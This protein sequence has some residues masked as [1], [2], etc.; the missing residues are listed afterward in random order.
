MKQPV[1]L[2]LLT[3]L[4]CSFSA[5]AHAAD[6]AA[7]KPAPASP[8]LPA[9]SQAAPAAAQK[10][11]EAAPAQ[12]TLRLGHVDIARVAAE[13]E[14]GKAEQTQIGELKKKLQTP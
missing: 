10:S 2:I 8:P 12:Q 3:L 11:P 9:A 13:S 5:S 1:R 4:V 6:P 7:D 14:T